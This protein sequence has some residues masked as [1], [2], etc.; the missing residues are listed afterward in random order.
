MPEPAQAARFAA[1]LER[2]RQGEPI[3]YLLGQ[4]EFWSLELRVTPD[5]LIPR[6]ETELLLN[7][8]WIGC[9]QIRR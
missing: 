3:A 9:R 2:R 7:W 1:W 6:P 8:P 4:R 5:T